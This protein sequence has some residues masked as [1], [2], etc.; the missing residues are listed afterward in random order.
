MV[1]FSLF[2]IAFAAVLVNGLFATASVTPTRDVSTLT[3][4]DDPQGVLIGCYPGGAGGCPCPVDNFGDNGVLIN[5][6]PGYQCAYPNG[7]CAWNDRNGELDNVAQDNCPSSA[8]CPST[9]C[10]CPL[11]KHNDVGVM[12]NFFT[13]Y[14][15]AYPNGACTWDDNGDLTNVRQGNCP[16]S[17]RCGKFSK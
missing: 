7:A 16:V 1:S 6:F 13:G 14:Q 11:D 3:K 8:P 12:I 5:V 17:A 9:G 15:C 4:R 10:T 2:T